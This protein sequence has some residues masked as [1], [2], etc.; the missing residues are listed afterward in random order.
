MSPNGQLT[1][2]AF[3]ASWRWKWRAIRWVVVDAVFCQ[4]ND[5]FFASERY[6]D[7]AAL[8]STSAAKSIMSRTAGSIPRREVNMRWTMPTGVPQLASP[9]TR[10][11]DASFVRQCAQGNSATPTPAHAALARIP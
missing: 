7:S 1:H 10:W 8:R 2:F 9:G 3:R 11:P 6:S 5:T 4:Q